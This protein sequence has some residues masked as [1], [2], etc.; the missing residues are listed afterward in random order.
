MTQKGPESAGILG[1]LG[2]TRL[3]GWRL[4]VF[5]FLFMIPLPFR[6]WPA[7]IVCS[8]FWILLMIALLGDVG[9]NGG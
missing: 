9:E 7:G 4:L 2:I 5:I 6:P 3:S 1:G 8:S